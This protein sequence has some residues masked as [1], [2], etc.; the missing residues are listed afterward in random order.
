MANQ[1]DVSKLIVNYFS[2]RFDANLY[3][4]SDPPRSGYTVRYSHSEIRENGWPMSE[5]IGLY[6]GQKERNMGY[7]TQVAVPDIALIREDDKEVKIL[8]EVESSSKKNFKDMLHC[9]GAIAMAD[10]YSPSYKYNQNATTERPNYSSDGNDYSIKQIILFILVLG[11]Q[12][13]Q[14]EEMRRRLIQITNEDGSKKIS[15]Y[16]DSDDNHIG[17]FNKFKDTLETIITN[18]Q[19]DLPTPEHQP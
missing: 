13:V 9:I 11:E 8:I 4:S 18:Q 7:L 5:D 2:N 14:F 17:L 10:V 3:R 16:F 1:H 6:V 12:R 19:F 15:V